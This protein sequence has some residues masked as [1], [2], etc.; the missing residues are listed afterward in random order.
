M[1]GHTEVCRLLL[2]AGVPINTKTRKAITPLHFACQK[3]VLLCATALTTRKGPKGFKSVS[4]RNRL[5]EYLLCLPGPYPVRLV[6]SSRQCALLWTADSPCVIFPTGF[7]EAVVLCCDHGAPNAENCACG[8]CKCMGTGHEETVQLLL[9]RNAAPYMKDS[10]GEN[11]LDKS[12]NSEACRC[13]C[14]PHVAQAGRP[15]LCGRC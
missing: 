9:K 4:E 3:G 11:A 7:E 14:V 13:V 6:A 8:P 1:N 15:R 12:K 5:I 2:N 10:K